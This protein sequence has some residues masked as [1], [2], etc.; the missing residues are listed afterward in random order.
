MQNV[1]EGKCIKIDDIITLLITLLFIDFALS[2][3]TIL[4]H[5][6][7]IFLVVFGIFCHKPIPQIIEQ[8]L[9]V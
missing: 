6:L 4:S 2:G 8:Q 9:R 7:I 1:I 3:T 5:L